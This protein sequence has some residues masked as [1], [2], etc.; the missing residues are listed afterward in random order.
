MC[1]DNFDT[2]VLVTGDGDFRWMVDVLNKKFGKKVIIVASASNVNEELLVC[3]QAYIN[4]GDSDILEKI[5]KD[6]SRKSHTDDEM[7]IDTDKRK[8]NG[9]GE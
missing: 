6:D 9:G 7:G 5:K 1:L 4:I 8:E 3:A 2:L